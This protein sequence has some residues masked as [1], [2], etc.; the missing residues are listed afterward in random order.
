MMLTYQEK[1][2]V[3]IFKQYFL[4]RT[5]DERCLYYGI[6][7][8]KA[9]FIRFVAEMDGVYFLITKECDLPQIRFLFEYAKSTVAYCQY[10]EGRKI[11]SYFRKM[12]WRFRYPPTQLRFDVRAQFVQGIMMAKLQCQIPFDF[13]TARKFVIGADISDFDYL[14][15]LK[16]RY[17]ETLVEAN[18]LG[19]KFFENMLFQPGCDWWQD[20]QTLKNVISND[21]ERVK[22]NGRFPYLREFFRCCINEIDGRKDEMFWPER[23]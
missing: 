22:Q 7:F 5:S 13:E 8:P 6:Q 4:N 2:T 12:D 3:N 17:K 15:R 19:Y 11:R 16:Q 21:Y 14:L 20:E 18:K 23:D 9:G 10:V 1:P